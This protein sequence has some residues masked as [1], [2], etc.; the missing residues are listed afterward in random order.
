LDLLLDSH[1]VLELLEPEKALGQPWVS[2]SL[3]VSVA[4]FWELAIK[5]RQGKLELPA[6][7]AR[8][9]EQLERLGCT[10]LPI[11]AAHAVIDVTPWPPT[12][13]P[14]DRLLLA[15]CQVEGLRLVTRDRKL[16]DHPLAWR[17]ASA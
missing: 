1:L 5:V 15:V 6:P 10:L 8:L 4:S 7:L 9:D 13:D 12:K 2:E 3:F 17:G 16:V 14:F 11:Q